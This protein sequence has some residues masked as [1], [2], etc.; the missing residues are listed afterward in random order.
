MIG[1]R[2]L[3]WWLLPLAIFL[4]GSALT[5]AHLAGRAAGARDCAA[6]QLQQQHDQADRVREL[7]RAL[8]TGQQQL[9]A[10]EA[11]AASHQAQLAQEVRHVQRPPLAACRP[12][13]ARSAPEAGR[14]VLPAVEPEAEPPP[15]PRPAPAGDAAPAVLLTAHAVRLWDSALAGEHLPRAGCSATEPASPACAAETAVTLADALENHTVNAALCAVDRARLAELNAA[16]HRI[17]GTAP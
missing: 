17:R 2:P 9:R 11:A 12:A 10:A 14:P 1:V 15:Q 16:I 13:A 5:L 8:A 4:A 3:T 7:Q 6:R